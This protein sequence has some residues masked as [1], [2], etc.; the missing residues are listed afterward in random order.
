MKVPVA[1]VKRDIAYVTHHDVLYTDVV[2]PVRGGGQ[3][4]ISVP[5]DDDTRSHTQSHTQSSK[6]LGAQG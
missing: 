3:E 2:L 6:K 1:A 5:Y 4:K